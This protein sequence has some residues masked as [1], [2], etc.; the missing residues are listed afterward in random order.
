MQPEISDKR[1]PSAEVIVFPADRR[2]GRIESLARRI[3][4]AETEALARR[5]WQEA[6]SRLRAEL[7]ANGFDHNAQENQIA[8]MAQAVQ[9]RIWQLQSGQTIAGS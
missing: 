1:L 6:V 9:Q 7:I 2:L 4:H 3:I 8:Y 5:R